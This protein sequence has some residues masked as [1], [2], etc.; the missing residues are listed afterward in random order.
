[1]LGR[2]L[3]SGGVPL[4]LRIT[5]VLLVSGAVTHLAENPAVS[6]LSI[7]A[8][9]ILFTC[10]PLLE[11]QEELTQTA[12]T[13]TAFFCVPLCLGIGMMTGGIFAVAEQPLLGINLIAT[14]AILSFLGFVLKASYASGPSDW[15]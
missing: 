11:R 3:T 1:M 15:L 14:G 13:Q 9:L 4:A 10:G 6:L 7:L 12:V 2:S 8:G 5:G